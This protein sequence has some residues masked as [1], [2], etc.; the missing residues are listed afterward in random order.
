MRAAG[1]ALARSAAVLKAH[2]GRSG[3]R[4]IKSRALSRASRSA[5]YRFTLR[6]IRDRFGANRRGR[7]W[8]RARQTTS[9]RPSTAAERSGR[10]VRGPATWPTPGPRSRRPA[11]LGRA[12]GGGRCTRSASTWS[13]TTTTGCAA[14]GFGGVLAVGGGSAAPPRLIE[15]ALAPARRGHRIARRAG[16]QGHHVRHRRAEPQARRQHAHDAHRHGRWRGGARRAA[17]GCR[18][19]RLPVRVTALVPAAENSLV[20]LGDAP[21]RRHAPL[22]RPHQRDQ[23]HRRRGAARA[24]R[25]AGLCGRPAAAHRA[26][27]HRHADRRDEGRARHCAP[28]GC[29]R[30]PTTWR[31]RCSPPAPAAGEPLWRMPLVEDT[32]SPLDSAVADAPQRAGQPGR[33]HRGA[34]PAPVQPATCRGR[35]STSPG[36]P[37]PT[38]TTGS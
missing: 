26:G 7:R 33:D 3:L 15:A 32:M 20:R 23:Q 16:R 29:S 1:A 35:T 28:A 21:E 30:P 8:H 19:S 37:A 10:A 17:A 5:A 11:W 4:P 13:C 14:Q 34:V 2:R 27:R 24:R 36:R 9:S 25:R 12:G 31:P 38:R 6:P 22:R 18:A